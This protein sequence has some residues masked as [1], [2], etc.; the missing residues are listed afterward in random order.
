MSRPVVL[1]CSTD[2][3]LELCGQWCSPRSS[4][5]RSST[6]TRRPS[7]PPQHPD[8]LMDNIIPPTSGR[9]GRGAPRTAAHRFTQATSANIAYLAGEVLQVGAYAVIVPQ[10]RWCGGGTINE[11]NHRRPLP[12]DSGN[13]RSLTVVSE[14]FQADSAAAL[15][16]RGRPAPERVAAREVSESGAHGRTVCGPR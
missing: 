12:G 2:P 15:G 4:A 5:A 11:I 16:S 13:A 6:A 9:G 7:C 14:P 10:P 8:Y 3:R 1:V